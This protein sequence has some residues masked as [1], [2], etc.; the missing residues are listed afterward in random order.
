[1]LSYEQELKIHKML[2][3]GRTHTEIM[4]DGEFKQH[5]ISGVSAARAIN[6]RTCERVREDIISLFMSGLSPNAVAAKL[7]VDEDVVRAVRRANLLHLRR[8]TL[9]HACPKCGAA[10]LPK[11]K[12]EYMP[13]KPPQEIS[14]A[15]AKALFTAADDVVGLARANIIPNVLFFDIALRC[16]NII[17]DI[18]GEGETKTNPA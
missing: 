17:S 16:Q 11:R 9:P 14:Q 10:I 3:E 12:S 4:R 2:D 1:M 5:E 8:V 7:S 15:A 18:G 6:K 13:S